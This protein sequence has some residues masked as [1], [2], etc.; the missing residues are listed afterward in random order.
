MEE[1]NVT[2]F[3][4][5]DFFFSPSLSKWKAQLEEEERMVLALPKVLFC[6][7]V[8]GRLLAMEGSFRMNEQ[9]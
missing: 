7:W 2:S 8:I 6:V 5:P 9:V 4:L 3:L 1:R